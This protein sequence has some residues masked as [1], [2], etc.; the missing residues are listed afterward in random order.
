MKNRGLSI[1]TAVWRLAAVS[2]LV[3]TASCTTDPVRASAS[4][5]EKGIA[6]ALARSD[7]NGYT[8]NGCQ[9]SLRLWH[10]EAAEAASNAPN[11]G[12]F[13]LGDS[14]LVYQFVYLIG[15]VEKPS[16]V[17]QS[18]DSTRTISIPSADL[19]QLSNLVIAARRDA[20]PKKASDST[21]TT[22]V[23][24]LDAQGHYFAVAP[25]DTPASARATDKAIGL[26]GSFSEGAP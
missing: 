10:D 6:E 23:V 26:L 7:L 9:N 2:T 14:Y 13:F 1:L 15:D 16:L 8:K 22:C 21:H 18:T 24:F 25:D 11:G 12:L 20:P 3:V 5:T 19:S 4:S 17:I